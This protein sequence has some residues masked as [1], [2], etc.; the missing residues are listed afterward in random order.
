[1]RDPEEPS[2][3][4]GSPSSSA[5]SRQPQGLEHLDLTRCVFLT[6]TAILGFRPLIEVWHWAWDTRLCSW[7][8]GWARLSQGLQWCRKSPLV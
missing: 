5:G 6:H 2:P 1:M 4:E 3:T 8:R 7:I